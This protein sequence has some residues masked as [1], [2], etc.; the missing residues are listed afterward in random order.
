MKRC[1]F[2][3][4]SFPPLGTAGVQRA[5]QFVRHLPSFGWMPTVLT[6]KDDP[7]YQKDHS[8]SP[9]VPPSVRVI[10][11]PML[12]PLLLFKVLWKCRLHRVAEFLEQFLLFP[13]TKVGWLPFALRKAFEVCRREKIDV[14]YTTSPPETTQLVGL[15]LKNRL[16]LPWVVDYRNE[17][18]TNPYGRGTGVCLHLPWHSRLERKVTLSADRVITLSPAHTEMLIKADP[19]AR[20]KYV[21]IENGFDAV[22]VEAAA[23]RAKTE[24]EVTS[25]C[26][27][28]ERRR[29]RIF[30]LVYAGAFHSKL[31]PFLFLDTL[32]KLITNGVIDESRFRFSVAGY[33]WELR[34]HLGRYGKWIN[35]AGYLAHED[36]LVLMHRASALLLMIRPD[37]PRTLPGK[38]Y[39]YLAVGKPILALVPPN[40]LAAKII[41]EARS[42]VIVA[43]DDVPA[44]SSALTSMYRQWERDELEVEPNWEL[45]RRYERYN[46]AQE[47]A[48]ILDAACAAVEQ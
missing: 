29:Q 26:E 31:T 17:W 10:R 42:G 39:E 11:A 47:L 44:I 7:T 6:V 19:Q 32:Q 5:V 21:T 38:L 9:L 15:Y 41:S 24:T 20:D 30:N 22:E 27:D 28:A 25:H 3:T 46:L 12:S 48:R 37:A 4:H 13:D 45:I 36:A 8:L 23:K 33:P 35:Y 16:K 2:I 40:G 34:D 1:L 14:V 43:P 18:T